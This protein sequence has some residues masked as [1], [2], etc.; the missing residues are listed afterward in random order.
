MS[1]LLLAM[2]CGAAGFLAGWPRSAAATPSCFVFSC[3]D[4][5]PPESNP[6]LPDRPRS[7]GRS[8]SEDA[9]LVACPK[10][11][12]SLHRLVTA[13]TV[14]LAAGLGLDLV[15]DRVRV[16]VELATDDEPLLSSLD[17]FSE[18]RYLN[19]IQVLA[20]PWALCPLA[21]LPEVLFVRLP[22]TAQPAV[23]TEGVAQTRMA[24]P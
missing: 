9:L 16:I 2:I 10:L 7:T 15:E 3:P 8:P 21:D 12:E 22:Y 13:P 24:S 14:E 11:A 6:P 1:W 20:P 19:L 23:A 5:V 4:P 17:A 18:L